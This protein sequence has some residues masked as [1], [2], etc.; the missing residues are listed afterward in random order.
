MQNPTPDAIPTAFSHHPELWFDDG[1][2]VLVAETTA[3]RVHRSTLCRHSSVFADLFSTPQP[4]G[5]GS[6]NIE[7]CPVIRMHDSAEEFTQLLRAC[8][9][10][11]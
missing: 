7:G 5:S 10:P 1:S 9:D 8:Y 6:D 2:V 3:F 4:S 11:L